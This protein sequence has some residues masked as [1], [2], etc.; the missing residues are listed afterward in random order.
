MLA[1]ARHDG[2]DGPVVAYVRPHDVEVTRRLDG[3]ASWPA[4]VRQVVPLGGLVR[5]EVL[6]RDGAEIRAQISRE[7][8][9]ELD[10]QVGD[11]IYVVPRQWKVFGD[12]AANA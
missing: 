11:E 8:R 6:L 2:P 5:L 3:H 7:R 1:P 10:I 9:S 12:R 4:R